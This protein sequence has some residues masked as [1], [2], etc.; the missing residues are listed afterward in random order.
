M[1]WFSDIFLGGRGDNAL[2]TCLQVVGVFSPRIALG[3]LCRAALCLRIEEPRFGLI[4]VAMV[5]TD[6][7]REEPPE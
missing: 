2:K 1:V 5:T 7:G 6:G 4:E 3:A